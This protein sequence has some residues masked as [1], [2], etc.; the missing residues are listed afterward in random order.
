M[1]STVAASRG[2]DRV[3]GEG[4]QKSPQAVNDGD[5]PAASNDLNSYFDWWPEKGKTEWIEYTFPRTAKVS[6]AEVYWFD[7]TG[8][9]EVRVPGSWRIRSRPA[10]CA[11]KSPCSPNGRPEWKSGRLG[12]LRRRPTA[13][14]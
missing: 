9:G 12:E 5:E 8:R 4:I 11:S 14:R 6:Q 2:G 3:T 13:D 7:D 10:P 1:N